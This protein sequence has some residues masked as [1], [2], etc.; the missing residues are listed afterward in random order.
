MHRALPIALIPVA[1]AFV[2]ACAAIPFISANQLLSTLPT[3]AG[4]VDFDTVRVIDDKSLS[5]HLVDDVLSALGKRRTEAAAVF[6]TSSIGGASIGAVAVQGVEGPDLLLACVENWSAPAV[7]ARSQRLAN[8]TDGWELEMRSGQLT[9]F[10]LRGNIAFVVWS[11]ERQV[12]EAV[13]EDM[14]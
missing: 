12:L 5:G 8:G 11:E 1:F 9:V 4:G 14:P 7:I 10:Y 3:T 2:A 13:L 6:R